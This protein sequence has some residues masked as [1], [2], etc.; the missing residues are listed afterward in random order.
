[1]PG[2]VICHCCFPSQQSCYNY[3]HHEALSPESA[4]SSLSQ[5]ILLN[6]RVDR[7]SVRDPRNFILCAS[8]PEPWKAVTG[9]RS[10]S[11]TRQG[12][13]HTSEFPV[14][15]ASALGGVIFPVGVYS[16]EPLGQ[17]AALQCRTR[18]ENYKGTITDGLPWPFH[19]EYSSWVI[20]MKYCKVR[21]GNLVQRQGSQPWKP[22]WSAIWLLFRW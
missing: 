13:G 3:I 17:R 21:N 15:S 22:V 19:V 2:W 10:H 11:W 7:T 9:T 8:K 18:L 16:H 1:M 6:S 14:L 12:W 5:R 20:L 4:L